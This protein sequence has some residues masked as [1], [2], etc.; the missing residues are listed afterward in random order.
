GTVAGLVAASAPPVINETVMRGADIVLSI[1]GVVFALVLAATMG[2][3][4]GSTVFALSVVFIPSFTRV[5]RAAAIRVIE[6]DYVV[7][8][9]LYGRT[10][11]F[12]LARHVLPNI[13]SVLI[14]QFTLYFAVGILTE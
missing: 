3:G 10:R 14:V 8:A 2:A 13:L 4:I 12:I 6:E 9:T 7:A 11:V 5:V 1:P